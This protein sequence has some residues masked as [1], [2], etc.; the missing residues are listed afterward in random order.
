MPIVESIALALQQYKAEHR[1]SIAV[2]AK[3]LEIAESSLQSYIKGKAN[4]R[5]STIQL[6]ADKMGLS[7]AEL[8]SGSTPSWERSEDLIR[9]TKE[10]GCLTTE[11]QQEAI[12]HFRALAT[13]LYRNS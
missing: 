10:F 8:I 2:M 4:P 7:A 6:L 9:A 11:E 12:Q 5:A 3:R 13:L 1:I